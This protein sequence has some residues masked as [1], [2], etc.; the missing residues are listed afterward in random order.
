MRFLFVSPSSKLACGSRC[1]FRWQT[2][3]L[4]RHNVTNTQEG[5]GTFGHPR[6]CYYLRQSHTVGFFKF[7]KFRWCT[8]RS[9][10]STVIFCRYTMYIYIPGLFSVIRN[11][12]EF[13]LSEVR[14]SPPFMT[15]WFIWNQKGIKN[16]TDVNDTERKINI[17]ES[18]N[19]NEKYYCF[20]VGF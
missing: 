11:V 1:N 3:E 17:R 6:N 12:G 19:V 2:L 5:A 16:N 14:K 8:T 7:R 18:E 13:F 15:N 20:V 10:F 4:K 9:R